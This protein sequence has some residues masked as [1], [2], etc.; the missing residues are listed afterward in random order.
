MLEIPLTSDGE[1]IFTITLDEILYEIRVLY[2]TRLVLWA[3]D[4]S[5]DGNT[6]VSGI[7]LVTGGNLMS[8][9][10]V[11]PTNLYLVN[12]TGSNDDAGPD[13]LGTDIRLF[14]LTDEEVIS[15]TPV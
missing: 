8:A 12:T 2:N 1:Q 13:N 14:Q 9:Y 15:V 6:I 3:M 11:G 4:I 10:N 5:S 7:A